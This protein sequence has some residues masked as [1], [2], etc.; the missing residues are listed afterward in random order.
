MQDRFVSVQLNRDEPVEVENEDKALDVCEAAKLDP[1]V[2]AVAILVRR[3]EDRPWS[4][5]HCE[6]RKFN[7]KA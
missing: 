3:R 2:H 6:R 5:A 1:S 4:V 7:W